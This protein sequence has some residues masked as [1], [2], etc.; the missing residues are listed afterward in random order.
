MLKFYDGSQDGML[1]APLALVSSLG[2]VKGRVEPLLRSDASRNSEDA[3]PERNGNT[4][5]QQAMVVTGG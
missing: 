4:N 1:S 3:E 5:T 2:V